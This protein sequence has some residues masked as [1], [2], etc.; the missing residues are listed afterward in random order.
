MT[1]AIQQLILSVIYA[2]LAITGHHSV[3]VPW[4]V[5]GQAVTCV[6]TTD[7]HGNASLGNCTR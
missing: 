2:V 6:L 1:L 5:N 3:T 4:N 7:S